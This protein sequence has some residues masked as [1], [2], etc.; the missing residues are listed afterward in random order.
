MHVVDNAMELL[1]ELFLLLLDVLVLLKAYFILILDFRILLLSLDNLLL[2]C[3]ELVP[4]LVVLFL[5]VKQLGNL[6]LD[7]LKRLD[8]HVVVGVLDHLLTVCLVFP[9]LLR[10]K[11]RTQC[12]DHV[13]VQSSDVV[14]VVVDFLILSIMLL[15]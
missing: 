13:H 9:C 2:L 3:S 7:M 5:E 8:N 11:V 4:D 12:A 15:F 14:V 1:K 6:L 10:L